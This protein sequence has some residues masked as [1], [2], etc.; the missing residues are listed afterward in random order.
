[1]R[2]Q[3][4]ESP[5]RLFCFVQSL[6]TI[7]MLLH[8]LFFFLALHCIAQFPQG[9]RDESGSVMALLF[10][11]PLDTSKTDCTSPPASRWLQGFQSAQS[12]PEGFSL[13]SG[14]IAID[15]L[16][17]DD[18]VFVRFRLMTNKTKRNT[19]VLCFDSL[20]IVNI[21]T[22]LF[23]LPR[24]CLLFLSLFFLIKKSSL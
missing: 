3:L 22:T 20:N 6:A 23:C 14:F 13:S 12:A 9:S 21:E 11:A 15:A 5:S 4:D 8:L 10:R 18:N 2:R 16:V 1:M 7:E 24:R 17:L 19:T